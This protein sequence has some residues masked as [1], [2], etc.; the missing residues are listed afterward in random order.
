MSLGVLS[1]INLRGNAR[2]LEEWLTAIFCSLRR[3]RDLILKTYDLARIM[4]DAG[5]GTLSLEAFRHRW[6]MSAFACCR[7]EGSQ[8]WSAPR[9]APIV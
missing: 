9:V 7:A 4:R 3:P 2:L 6:R 1:Q 5:G 8:W